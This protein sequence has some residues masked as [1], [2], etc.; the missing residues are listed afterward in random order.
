VREVVVG[1]RRVVRDGRHA[2]IADV[3]TELDSAITAVLA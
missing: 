1:G 2:L 3:A